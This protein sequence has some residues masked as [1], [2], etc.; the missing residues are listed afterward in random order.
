MDV[1]VDQPGND[2]GERVSQFCGIGRRAADILA[3]SDRD[4]RAALEKNCPAV[5]PVPRGTGEYLASGDDELHRRAT[6]VRWRST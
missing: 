4:D 3:R 5:E 6:P 2:R 1:R